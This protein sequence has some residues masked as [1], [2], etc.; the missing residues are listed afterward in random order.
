MAATKL[1][2]KEANFLRA[3]AL[4]EDDLTLRQSRALEARG[5]AHYSPLHG[6][7][8]ISELG[9]RLLA[10]RR[11]RPSRDVVVRRPSRRTGRA[12]GAGRDRFNPNDLTAQREYDI[13]RQDMRFAGGK[14][15]RLL[16]EAQD[17]IG[18][19]LSGKIRDEFPREYERADLAYSHIEKARRALV[20]LERRKRSSP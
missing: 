15:E 13:R 20:G 7:T 6:R 8:T 2:P 3:I 19:E 9:L 12:R 14:L 1:T 17:L 4:R 18:K 10:E 5:L 11:A 16:R